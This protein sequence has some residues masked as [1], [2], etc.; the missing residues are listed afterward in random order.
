MEYILFMSKMCIYFDCIE[1]MLFL[2]YLHFRNF[3]YVYLVL[4]G[5]L[6]EN[7]ARAFLFQNLELNPETMI[8]LS[9]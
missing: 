7:L 1:S 2:I 5:F 8:G 3:T 6:I 9:Y 4:I